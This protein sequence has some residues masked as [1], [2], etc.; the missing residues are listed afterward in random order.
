MYICKTC[1][2]NSKTK[3]EYLCHMESHSTTSKKNY[4]C[5]F[6]NITFKNKKSFYDHIEI[7]EKNEP[8]QEKT[9]I[10]CK[11]CK[12]MCSSIKG[13]LTS[14]GYFGVFKST[15]KQTKVFKD[16]CPSRSLYL[17]GG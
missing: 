8:K 9:E 16:F 11:H 14:K 15:K 17:T 4:P 13:Q 1:K 10:L 12:L 5:C 3:N 7:H 2:K 6:C